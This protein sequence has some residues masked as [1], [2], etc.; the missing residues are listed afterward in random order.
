[1]SDT[2]LLGNHLER[3]K[4]TNEFYYVKFFYILFTMV[5]AFY[6][7]QIPS[8]TTAINDIE[9]RCYDSIDSKCNADIPKVCKS[10]VL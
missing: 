8:V 5:K 7:R 2:F 4:S 1:M 6:Q 3:V 9:L 10:L